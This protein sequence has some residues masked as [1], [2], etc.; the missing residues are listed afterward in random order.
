MAVDPYNHALAYLLLHR[1]WDIRTARVMEP[2]GQRFNLAL[3]LL[4]TL[5]PNTQLGHRD[6]ALANSWFGNVTHSIAP[7]GSMAYC[8][9]SL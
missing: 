9:A 3:T 8:S 5:I 4:P 1:A 6:H 2:I 7:F